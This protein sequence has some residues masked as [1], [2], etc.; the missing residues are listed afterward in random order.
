MNDKLSPEIEH[1]TQGATI[2]ISTPA[3]V[4][5]VMARIPWLFL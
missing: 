5:M 3:K 1:E 2:T 4:A